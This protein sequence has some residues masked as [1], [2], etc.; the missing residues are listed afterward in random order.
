M[1]AIKDIVDLTTQLSENINDRKVVVELLKIQSLTL[2]LQAEQASIHESNIELREECLG[3]KEEIVRLKNEL[4]E[5]TSAS[6]NMA[7]SAPICP[8]CSTP[9]KPFYMSMVGKDFVELL[10]VTHECTQCKFT[11]KIET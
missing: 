2:K 10:G 11:K 6:S 1:G 8:N 3:L 4:H 7:E 5:M 9:N